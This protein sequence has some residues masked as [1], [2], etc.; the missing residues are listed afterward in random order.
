MRR[1]AFY[2]YAKNVDFW[3]W[4]ENLKVLFPKMPEWR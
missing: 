4:R 2:E 3:A 1:S